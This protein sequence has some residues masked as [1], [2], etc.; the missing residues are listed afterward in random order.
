MTITMVKKVN[1]DGT[2]CRKCAEVEQRLEDA[3]LTALID[4]TVIAD[5]R[6]PDSKGMQLAK[7]HGVDVAPFFIVESEDGNYTIYTVYF[8]FVKEVLQPRAGLIKAVA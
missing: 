7:K 1:A 2:A 6:D 3:G 4:H 8:Q 5:S